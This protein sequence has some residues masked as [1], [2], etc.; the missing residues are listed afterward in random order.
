MAAKLLWVF[1]L[2]GV[3][4]L[5]FLYILVKRTDYS[6]KFFLTA[7]MKGVLGIAPLLLLKY[8]HVIDKEALQIACGILWTYFVLAL[9]EEFSKELSYS[10][11]EHYR[12]VHHKV[13]ASIA[14]AGGFAFV[15]NLV[16]ASSF[17]STSGM[18]LVAGSRFLLNTTIHSTCIAITVL[19]FER[20]K[21]LFPGASEHPLHFFSILPAAL[22]HTSFNMLY[23]Y[24]IG[25]LSVPMVVGS[26][27]LLQ[28][29][30]HAHFF[31]LKYRRAT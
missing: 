15:E 6:W 23:A 13:F 4:Y 28:W 1:P 5:T 8:A 3:L 29:M 2:Y 19:Y 21:K 14:L 27:M 10:Y 18:L 26:V 9:L 20:L 11:H 22:V 30:Y 7:F 24:N 31:D 17:Y 16:F 25:F 12:G